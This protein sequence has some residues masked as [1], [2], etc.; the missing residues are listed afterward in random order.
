VYTGILGFVIGKRLLRRPVLLDFNDLI[1]QYTSQL[2]NLKPQNIIAK[3]A[4]LI[5]DSIVRGSD[6][7]IASTNYIKEYA[8]RLGVK[9]ERI[10]VIPNGVDTNFFDPKKYFAQHIESQM[11]L[12]GRKICVY[13]GRLDSWAGTNVILRISKAFAEKSPNTSF[14]VV[15]TGEK[16]VASAR[17]V[18]A[19]GGVAYE[20]VP[21]MLALADVVLVPFP[22]NEVS[23]AASPLKL[24][25]G[26]AMGKAIVASSVD[27]IREVLSHRESGMLVNPSDVA[28]WNRAVT[29]LL[30]D[31]SMAR[32][33]G[34]NARTLARERYDWGTLAVEYERILTE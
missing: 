22:D 6:K 30:N 10:I 33:L 1:A 5:Q 24:F 34:E 25:E 13:C 4:V 21:K 17:N 11:G 9:G 15:G 12:Q 27:G 14:L 3:L 32:Q 29:D 26:M 7:I 16:K 2:L 20:E 18:V 28:E 8:S 19:V 23:R 31:G